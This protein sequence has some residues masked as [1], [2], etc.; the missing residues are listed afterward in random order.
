MQSRQQRMQALRWG[1]L[2][3]FG[4]LGADLAEY[5]VDPA[6]TSEAAK[7]FGAA[8]QHH[9]RMVA[10]AVFLLLSSVFVVP[11]VFGLARA[12][13]ERGRWLG[14]VAAVFALLG[15]IGHGALA[16]LYLAWAAMPGDA[17]SRDEVIAAIE[18]M[19]EAGASAIVMP[20]VVA[21]PVALV[22]VFVAIVRAGLASRWLLIPAVAAPVVAI[23]GPGSSTVSTATAL[24][25][26]LIAT[27]ALAA[28]WFREPS[29]DTAPG[30]A[31]ATA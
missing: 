27:S 7:I 15:A 10:S 17:S 23:A 18:R 21:F 28:R 14:R 12:I 6:S 29:T 31:P 11:A 5:V 2:A 4:A 30:S 8:S 26:L 16:A 20:F 1:T 22:V 19:N 9:G 25:L 13:E 24:V 3:M